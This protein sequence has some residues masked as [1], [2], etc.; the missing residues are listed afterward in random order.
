MAIPKTRN[1]V[2]GLTI[3]ALVVVGLAVLAGGGFGRGGSVDSQTCSAATD[4]AFCDQDGDGGG[5]LNSE[6]PDWA[7]P[8]DG[9]GYG[10]S[11]DCGQVCT[12]RQLLGGAGFGGGCGRGQGSSIR[13]CRGGSS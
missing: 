10:A 8:S 7:C 13:A 4:G 5:V 9:S 1:W 2:I 11:D 3:V 12:G 6:D